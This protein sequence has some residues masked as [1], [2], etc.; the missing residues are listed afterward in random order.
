[1]EKAKRILRLTV[2]WLRSEIPLAAK[3]SNVGDNLIP[4]PMG[5]L[6]ALQR[7]DPWRDCVSSAVLAANATPIS[8][9]SRYSVNM[10][11]PNKMC[12]KV[13]CTDPHC[14][15]PDAHLFVTLRDVFVRLDAEERRDLVA[16]EID[17]KNAVALSDGTGYS[18]TVV[19]YSGV[20]PVVSPE[21]TM[22]PHQPGTTGRSRLLFSREKFSNSPGPRRTSGRR[23]PRRQW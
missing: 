1:M 2:Y 17:I 13:R 23:Y 18:V 4:N 9:S 12:K 14:A 21:P 22:P 19:R 5:Q 15:C 7:I 16:I 3:F 20:R 6:F 8:Y 10:K 11:F